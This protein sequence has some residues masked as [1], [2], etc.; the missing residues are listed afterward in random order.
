MLRTTTRSAFQ[1]ETQMPSP[2]FPDLIED[3]DSLLWQDFIQAL[4]PKILTSPGGGAT[5]Q[6]VPLHILVLSGSANS[7]GFDGARDQPGQENPAGLPCGTCRTMNRM[8]LLASRRREAGGEAASRCFPCHGPA[9]ALLA[10]GSRGLWEC[11][12]PWHSQQQP[13][14]LSSHQRRTCLGPPL[15]AGSALQVAPDGTAEHSLIQPRVCEDVSASS[16][17]TPTRSTALRPLESRWS[18]NTS[19]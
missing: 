17:D 18:E 7:Q 3:I 9:M 12:P 19:S 2:T 15:P 6:L 14:L 5:N 1:A 11:P 16:S 13:P 8:S 4:N 10:K